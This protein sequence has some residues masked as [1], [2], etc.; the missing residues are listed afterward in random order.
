M[1]VSLLFSQSGEGFQSALS[2]TPVCYKACGSVATREFS[3]LH[4]DLQPPMCL[5]GGSIDGGMSGGGAEEEDA[6]YAEAA[7]AELPH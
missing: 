7:E 6:D 4:W 3:S 2:Y 5:A 1:Q